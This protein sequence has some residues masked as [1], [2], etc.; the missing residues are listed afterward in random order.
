MNIM[1]KRPQKVKKEQ[2]Y[3]PLPSTMSLLTLFRMDLSGAAHGWRGRGGGV[4]KAPSLKSITHILQWLNF[5]VIP[6]L[7]K[8]RKIY[9]SRDTPPEFSWHQ[10]F[11]IG[12]Q[13]FFLYQKIQTRLHFTYIIS[14]YSA[15]FNT[16]G[17]LK[18]M[19][20]GNISH[21]VII[22]DYWVTNK[23]L[24]LHQ[25]VLHQFSRR[26]KNKCQNVL[27]AKSYVRRNYRGRTGGD[28]T[29]FPHPEY[30]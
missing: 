17:L 6:Y 4:Q 18:I 24:V 15:K 5:A 25:Q 7:R 30:G 3:L 9:E 29:F 20:F 28:S 11:F 14:N 22:I 10:H 8:N 23:T 13:Q 1:R 16:P 26:V 12:N 2:F 19:I 21:D 27:W